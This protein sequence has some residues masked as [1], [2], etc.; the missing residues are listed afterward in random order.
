MLWA[1]VANACPFCDA[2]GP[3]W[4]QASLESAGAA[5]AR[6]VEV[7]AAAQPEAIVSLV[8]VRLEV[9]EALRFAEGVPA[10]KSFTLEVVDA[11]AVGSLWLCTGV[12]APEL[13]WSP[14]VELTA[15][16]AAYFAQ[17][18]QQDAADP[19]RLAYF[20]K[21]LEHADAELAAD[22]YG[23]FAAASFAEVFAAKSHYSHA[24][25]WQWIASET[26]PENRRGLYYTLL[27]V[28]GDATDAARLKQM[29]AEPTQR[30]PGGFDALVACYVALCGEEGLR[31]IEEQFLSRDAN[32]RDV[33]SVVMALR[34]HGEEQHVLPRTRIAKAFARLVDRPALA[35]QVIPD[36][37]RWEH[38]D[39]LPALVK[40][41]R[42]APP[43]DA[44]IRIPIVSYV[45]ACPLPEAKT[46]IE[47]LAKIDPKAVEQA[48][49]LSL[50]GARLQ[51]S[52][53]ETSESDELSD[54]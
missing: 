31:E 10:V 22:A 51:T 47:E 34:F 1:S 40:L 7:E 41:Y 52:R 13:S 38:W 33:V 24:K 20:A 44:W 27:G 23:E 17:S 8:K 35:V 6:V 49:A 37:A 42:E 19:E 53:R 43:E 29:L 50:F 4:R 28:C 11:P 3:T 39:A 36:L 32:P 5:V 21:F 46:A 45:R 2:T 54:R 15:E 16:R 18:R 30:P 25:L 12:G 9:V 14:L 48:S 26:T